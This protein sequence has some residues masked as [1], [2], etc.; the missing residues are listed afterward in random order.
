MPVDGYPLEDHASMCSAGNASS[1]TIDARVTA[2]IYTGDQRSVLLFVD[3]LS[4]AHPA[5]RQ[6]P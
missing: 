2:M 6:R 1:V 5:E 4:P 3:F